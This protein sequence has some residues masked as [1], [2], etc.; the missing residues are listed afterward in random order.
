MWHAVMNSE[1]LWLFSQELHK[2]KIL[3]SQY[4][5]IDDGGVFQ[6]P[7]LTEELLAIDSCYGK[8]HFF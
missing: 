6:A 3:H 1:Q 8:K 5:G 2:I 7:T 4:S